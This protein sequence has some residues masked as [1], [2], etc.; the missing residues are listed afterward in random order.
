MLIAGSIRIGSALAGPHTS[1]P[2]GM[3]VPH[4]LHANM[5]DLMEGELAS[6][7][8]VSRS[9]G[10]VRDKTVRKRDAAN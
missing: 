3:F 6:V 5:A 10:S 4:Q 1:Y 7:T 8:D 2:T 9:D